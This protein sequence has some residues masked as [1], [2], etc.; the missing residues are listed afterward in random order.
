MIV[1]F[2]SNDTPEGPVAGGGA[3]GA[4]CEC[5][6]AHAPASTQQL[7]HGPRTCP[8]RRHVHCFRRIMLYEVDKTDCCIVLVVKTNDSLPMWILELV[9]E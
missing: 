9:I 3:D 5:D 6:G 7:H 2:S 1:E 8:K 4:V